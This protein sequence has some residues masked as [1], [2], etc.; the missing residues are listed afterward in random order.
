LSP[1]KIFPKKVEVLPPA[2]KEVTVKPTDLAIVRQFQS[3]ADAIREAPAP[4]GAT[5]TI[6]V[7]ASLLLSF[8]VLVFVLQVDRIV[9][10]MGGKIVPTQMVN[11]LQPVDQSIIKTMDVR[12]GERVKAG[13][14]LATLDP[15][16]AV[17]TATQLRQ[18]VAS[19]EA[20]VA[21]IDAELAGRPLEFPE[22]SDQD[23]AEYAAL[24]RALYEQ[25][26]SQYKA[27]INSYDA[28]I[29]QTNATIQR[30]QGDEGRYQQREQ[31][32]K[33]IENMRTTL[34]ESGSGSRLNQ[35]ISQDTR[36]EMLR[37]LESTHNSLIEAQHTLASLTADK[38]A[39]NQQW[40]TQLSQELVQA[41]NQLDTARAQLEKAAKLETLVKLT[42]PVASIVLTV[43]KLSPGSVLKAGDPF[44][45]LMPADSP[46]EAEFRIAS[47]DVGFVRPGDR[48]V[49]KIDA[50]NFVAHGTAEGRVRWVSAGAFTVD[51]DGK[52]TDGAYYKA[53]CSIDATNFRGVPENFQ[54]IPGMTLIADVNVGSRSVAMYILGGVLRGF[55][56]AMR[57]P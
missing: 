29:K 53:R 7:L 35:L 52:P 56:E 18:Q 1:K 33:S 6:I 19:L 48:C 21:R 23:F 14:L 46:V 36:L 26:V 34:A 54:L 49:L 3:E 55:G 2:T 25:R 8:V 15:T 43:A 13:Q 11:V 44:I 20:Q 45:T 50:F 17:A 47:R 22:R 24:Q 30:L 28:K 10:S 40:S 38:E 57:E 32:A 12:E 39:F 4:R 31:I 5:A 42:A 51:D 41:R 27:Q 16:F 9:T 37:S